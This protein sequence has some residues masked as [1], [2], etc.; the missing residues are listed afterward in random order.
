MSQQPNQQSNRNQ[1]SPI[2]NPINLPSL[3]MNLSTFNTPGHDGASQRMTGINNDGSGALPA[4]DNHSG[5]RYGQNDQTNDESRLRGTHEHKSELYNLLRQ[6]S[7]SSQRRRR[8]DDEASKIEGTDENNNILFTDKSH[9]SHRQESP[10]GEGNR[11][12]PT[13]YKGSFAPN[14]QNYDDIK[15][16]ADAWQKEANDKIHELEEQLK[17]RSFKDRDYDLGEG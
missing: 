14:Q 6:S 13:E 3:S 9:I 16:P 17:Q 15:D 4:Q 5:F 1:V 10:A 8:E 11:H 12:V 7:T 2:A